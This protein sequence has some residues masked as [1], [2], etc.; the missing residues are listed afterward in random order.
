MRVWFGRVPCVHD[1]GT[2]DHASALAGERHAVAFVASRAQLKTLKQAVDE[3]CADF[4]ISDAEERLRVAET[5]SSLFDSGIIS[6]RDIRRRLEKA[7][8]PRPPA[9]RARA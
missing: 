1:A 5:V 4:G 8:P 3:Y 9:G 7:L 2:V 6:P